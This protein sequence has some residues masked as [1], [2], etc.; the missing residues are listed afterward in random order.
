MG[1]PDGFG[2]FANPITGVNGAL[3][4][5]QIM[6]PNFSIQRKTGWAIL[7]NGDAY[8][9]NITASGEITAT[10][11]EGSDFFINSSG[12]YFYSGTPA[13]GNLI[14]SITQ[15]NGT[16]QYGNAVYGGIVTYDPS[17]GQIA[18]LYNGQLLLFANGVGSGGGIQSDIYAA[19]ATFIDNGGTTQLYSGAIN[20]NTSSSIVM[21]DSGAGGGTPT[22]SLTQSALALGATVSTPPTPPSEFAVM[23]SASG[24]A[25]YV[26]GADGDA[27][28]TGHLLQ[29]T[30]AEQDISTT[31]QSGI[32]NL[33]VNIASGTTYYFRANLPVKGLS[34]N[35][36]YLTM[37]GTAT[38][39]TFR[40][41]ITW[42]GSGQ[43]IMNQ[44]TTL[45]TNTGLESNA[46]VNGDFYDC[47]I[48]GFIVCNG[49]GTL[50]VNG[51]S[52]ANAASYGVLAGST[53]YASPVV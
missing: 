45:G 50:T 14:D 27:Y 48:E 24:F 22:V 15:A 9:F 38:A 25:K 19:Q 30:T 5:Q 7:K 33:S 23:Y 8:F 17:T 41:S 29:H 4:Q 20:S 36:A 31:G 37:G 44:Q 32:T 18:Q 46:L 35:D 53:L 42:V 12:A 34:A 11:F 39:S 6:S 3:V 13:L 1:T 43:Q 28:V 47:V 21:Y 51:A 49:S 40:A 10:E 52:S 2:S 26:S 16:D